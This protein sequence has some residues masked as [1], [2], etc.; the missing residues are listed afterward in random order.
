MVIAALG[1]GLAVLR[2][3]G[4]LAVLTQQERLATGFVIGMGVIGW[5][6][7]FPG[8]AGVF[9]GPA[10]AVILTAMTAGLLCL[11][12]PPAAAG[13]E[14]LHAIEWLLLAGLAAV[15]LMDFAEGL[16]PAADADSMSYHFETPRRYLTEGAAFAIPRALDG[17]SQLLLQMTYGVALGLGG[18]PAVPLWTMV[19]GWGL[20]A[21]FYVLSRRHMS[22][23]WALIG[24]LCL[25]TTPAV[26]YG[27]GSGHVE[28]RCAAFA[29]LGAYAAAMAASGRGEPQHRTG[30]LLVA[31]L[32][33]GFFAGAKVT[34]VIFAFAAC[35]SMAGSGWVRRAA[36][37]SLIVAVSGTQWYLFNWSETGDPLYPL[38]WRFAD[39]AP[40]FAWD[41][42]AAADLRW[43]WSLE[44]P[45]PKNLLWFVLYP[46]RMVFAPPP[47][48]ESLRTGIG[49]AVILC[50]PFALIA[51]L[52]NRR[53]AYSPLFPM[54]LLALIV[55]AVWFFFGPSQRVRHLLTIYP[56]VLLCALAGA[57]HF[58]DRRMALRRVLIAGFA[59]LLAAQLAGQALFSKKFVDHLVSNESNTAFLESN[60]GG[61]RV[62]EWLNTHL[63]AGDRVVV[64]NRDW[65]YLLD[66][67]Y[68]YAPTFLQTQLSVHPDANDP[69]RFLKQLRA[70]GITHAALPRSSIAGTQRSKLG[71]FLSGLTGPG[72]MEQLAELDSR[73]ITSRTLPHLRNSELTYVVLRI[74][75]GKCAVP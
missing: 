48:I 74:D 17:V 63:S 14:P 35:V 44:T 9:G 27:T 55:Y 37:F 46:F 52:R 20:G 8:V 42:R 56:I 2:A 31:G 71:E 7:F 11:R 39:L 10:F 60:V 33:T 43:L 47:E 1:G 5:L 23:I 68:F 40:A 61:Y 6:A 62:V 16:S 64:V 75:A 18:K 58:T 49:P 66:V 50:L 73:T 69:V 29:V 34:G 53:A 21:V 51:L 22:R 13:K 57:A 25:M 38:L 54:L 15:M 36:V 30:W 45:F 67:P 12:T 70:L 24:T 3:A 41:A 32:C 4:L 28:A 19:S 72:C 65:L 59:A 26:I